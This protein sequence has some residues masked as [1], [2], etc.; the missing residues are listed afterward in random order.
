MKTL[1]IIIGILL[2]L[3]LGYLLLPEEEKQDSSEERKTGETEERK[4]DASQASCTLP[5]DFFEQLHAENTCRD[6]WVEKLKEKIQHIRDARIISFDPSKVK[7]GD[8]NA[9]AYLDQY[10]QNCER[11]QKALLRIDS[12]HCEDGKGIIRVFITETP[13][14]TPPEDKIAEYRKVFDQ[15]NQRSKEW[16]EQVAD[17]VGNPNAKISTDLGIPNQLDAYLRNHKRLIDQ[18]LVTYSVVLDTIHFNESG[19]PKH[20]FISHKKD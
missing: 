17:M 7:N 5:D 4:A 9:Q 2:L 3:F 15:G 19:L 1:R 10:L 13:I 6:S 12:V 18:Q 14:E 20:I 11:G 8:L 16:V